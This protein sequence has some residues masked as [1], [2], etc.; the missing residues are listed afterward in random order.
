M[1]MKEIEKIINHS[2]R[3]K[4]RLNNGNCPPELASASRNLFPETD[5]QG[6]RILMKK[7]EKI[8]R[9]NHRPKRRLYNGNCP[10][11]LASTRRNLFP[12]TDEIPLFSKDIFQITKQNFLYYVRLRYNNKCNN[13]I[14][15]WKW[16]LLGH[17]SITRSLLLY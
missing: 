11:E 17:N 15:G 8:I 9:H 1:L 13:G 16:F 6:N 3:P 7:I 4:R 5:D 10:P 14:K 2:H 12:E